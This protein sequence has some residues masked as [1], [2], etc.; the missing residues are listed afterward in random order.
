LF[1]VDVDLSEFA[2]LANLE[3]VV[4]KE[5]ESLV[6]NL[7]AQTHAKAIELASERL[8]TRRQMFVDA[9]SM[10]QEENV[11]VISLDAKA[12]WIDD[13]M[14]RHSMLDSLLSS[15]KAKRSRD[16]STYIVVPFDHSPGSGP[17]NK[18]PAQMDLVNV[19]KA[20]MKSRKIPWA[21]IE[22]DDQGRPRLGRLHSFDITDKPL[23]T[24]VGPGQGRGE[25]GQVRQGPTKIPFLAGVSVY[26]RLGDDGKVKRSVMTFRVASSKHREQGRWIAPAMDGVNI[27]ESVHDWALKTVEDEI[28]PELL[29]R[30][31]R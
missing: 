6:A 8:H 11:W 30:F 7:A 5:G 24:H 28:L 31:G 4:R 13:G 9:L 18:T 19:V 16:G 23:K 12:R 27:L 17:S 3:E 26:Q 15:P 2:E 21:K 22:K 1:R 25:V 20:E 29:A 14:P 10:Y